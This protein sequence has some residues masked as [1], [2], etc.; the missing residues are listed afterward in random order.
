VIIVYLGEE[1]ELPDDK[2]TFIRSLSREYET[3][4]RQ[5]LEQGIGEGKFREM[6]V[7]MVVR[8]L[9]GMCNW[10]VDWYQPDGQYS[11]DEIAEIFS[12]LI[13]KGCRKN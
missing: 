3:T 10:L 11:G 6:D 5:L 7:P 8:A 12:D 2:R 1:S 13:L 9:S 4:Y